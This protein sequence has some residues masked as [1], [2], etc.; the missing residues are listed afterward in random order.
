MENLR[1]PGVQIPQRLGG[2]VTR[3]ANMSPLKMWQL[4]QKQTSQERSSSKLIPLKQLSFLN[5]DQKQ[6][7]LDEQK[8]SDQL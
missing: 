8:V 1:E 3:S 6:A 7:R 4:T 2:L 5:S